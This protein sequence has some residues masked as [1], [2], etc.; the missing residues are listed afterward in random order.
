MGSAHADELQYLFNNGKNVMNGDVMPALSAS[1]QDLASKMRKYW[2]NFAR[3][4]NPNGAGLLSWPKVSDAYVNLLP[5]ENRIELF[6]KLSPS[7][8]GGIAT[9]HKT[10][11]N[12]LDY[13]FDDTHGCA[14]LNALMPI[15]RPLAPVMIY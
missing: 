15:A 5:Y 2:G 12:L 4:G 3:T 7:N 10:P 1:Q 6:Q 13:D 8:A 9:R 11:I 14:L